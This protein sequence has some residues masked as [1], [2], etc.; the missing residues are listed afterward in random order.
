MIWPLP[1]LLSQPVVSHYFLVAYVAGRAYYLKRE[2]LGA[3]GAKSY[4]R[5]KAWCSVNTSRGGGGGGRST[6]IDPV[7]ALY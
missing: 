3:R 2:E 1:H 4:D 6:L 5:E 7:E